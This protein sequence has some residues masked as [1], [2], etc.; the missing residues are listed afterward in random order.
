ML[1]MCSMAMAGT[2]PIPTRGIELR[3][4]HPLSRPLVAF[5]AIENVVYCAGTFAD[6][7]RIG[8]LRL[9]GSGMH[10]VFLAAFDPDL[11]PRWI[12]RMGGYGD[13][14]VTCMTA[15]PNGGVALGLMCGGQVLDV[16]AYTIGT[17][18]FTGKGG[19]DAVVTS[20]TGTGAIRWTRADGAQYSEFPTAIATSFNDIFV[21]GTFV[22][23]SRFGSAVVQ[24]DG[25]TSA[26]LQRISPTGESM[27]VQW[28]RGIQGS[29]QGRGRAEGG[30]ACFVTDGVVR[31]VVQVSSAI[32]WGNSTVESTSFAYETKAA[33][34][35][36]SLDGAAADVAML[37]PCRGDSCP[38]VTTAT[39]TTSLTSESL[40]CIVGNEVGFGFHRST[41]SGSD[42][43]QRFPVGGA[44]SVASVATG[45]AGD[46][47]L[48]GGRF[49]RAFSF[50]TTQLRPDIFTQNFS[51][52]DGFLISVRPDGSGDWA[53]AL[54]ASNWSTITSCAM[55][56]ATIAVAATVI[57]QVPV[58]TGYVGASLTDTLGALIMFESTVSDV[59]EM[60]RPDVADIPADVTLP[61]LDVLGKHVAMYCNAAITPSSLP[62]GLYGVLMANGTFRRLRIDDHGAVRIAE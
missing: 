37:T 3:G 31:A 19:Y 23:T 40:N 27:W 2:P 62:T 33:A 28:T 12:Q 20:V 32:S 45:G 54:G 47:M 26:Y 17:T 8:S 53:V 9:Y 7:M 56:G 58:G 5:D 43:V 39:A 42:I 22:G 14:S 16:P 60:P 6:S 48:A 24:D 11:R 46:N 49:E 15:L 30:M 41:N 61:V 21:C 51:L 59:A 10:D 29:L 44:R 52:Q 50:T 36:A 35:T 34:L 13:D 4:I 57:G 18:T 25:R 55:R 38:S 1:Y